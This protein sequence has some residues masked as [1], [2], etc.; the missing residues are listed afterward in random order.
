MKRPI[1]ILAA[2]IPLLFSSCQKKCASSSAWDATA[3]YYSGNSVS[4]GGQC[5]KATTQGRGIS[6]GAL[7]AKQQRSVEGM[8]S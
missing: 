7:A 4:Y 1:L 2:S 3:T 8:Y 5:W 6:A